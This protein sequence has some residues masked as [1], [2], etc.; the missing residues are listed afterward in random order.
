MNTVVKFYKDS[1]KQRMFEAYWNQTIDII[2]NDTSINTV[3]ET[4]PTLIKALE[5]VEQGAAS[6]EEKKAI[7]DAYWPIIYPINAPK[8]KREQFVPWMFKAMN[9]V[10]LMGNKPRIEDYY[11]LKDDVEYF[12]ASG[13]DIP[14]TQ[15]NRNIK[16]FDRPGL[17]HLIVKH[18]RNAKSISTIKKKYKEFKEKSA[19]IAQSTTVFY[20]G[21]EGQIVMPHTTLASQ[22]YGDQTKWCISAFEEEN[23]RFEGY[24]EDSPVLM[25]LTTPTEADRINYEGTYKSHKFAYV[26]GKW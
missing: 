21:P 13:N 5:S 20:D 3:F 10:D 15:E 11:R 7:F 26:E 24:Q 14:A 22:K 1:F 8:G 4:D 9:E 19:E 23:N 17:M 12:Y 6:A 2:T 25:F 16:N 18:R